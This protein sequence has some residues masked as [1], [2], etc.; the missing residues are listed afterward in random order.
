MACCLTAPSHYL[1][2]TKVDYSLVKSC[3]I[4]MREILQNMLKTS[5]LDMNLKMY[6]L[7]LQTHLPWANEITIFSVRI[8]HTICTQFCCAL[9]SQY[10]SSVD[11]CDICTY[12][13]QGWVP[14]TDRSYD[15]TNS[16]EATVRD[17]LV[18]LTGTKAQRKTTKG[19]R[20]LYFLGCSQWGDE[21]G[22]VRQKLTFFCIDRWHLSAWVAGQY[23][24]FVVYHSR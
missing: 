10:H 16:S 24:T 23:K 7:R 8:S 14:G 21:G 20:C 5:I 6:D 11:A 1:N 15:C 4:R 2:W 13:L 18:N 22:V 9:L 3:G 19:E 17:N 12:V